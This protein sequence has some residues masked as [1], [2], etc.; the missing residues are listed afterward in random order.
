MAP[1]QTDTVYIERLAAMMRD[2]LTQ[3]R[4]IVRDNEG[5]DLSQDE[6][7]EQVDWTRWRSEF[8]QND[9]WLMTRFDNWFA[10]PA[11]RFSLMAARFEEVRQGE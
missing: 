9:P 11:G 7:L 5:Q 4:T 8:A 10:A 1:V 3:I 6:I 2:I